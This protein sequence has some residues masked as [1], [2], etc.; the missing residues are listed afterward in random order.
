MTVPYFCS[1][2]SQKRQRHTMNMGNFEK[3]LFT[4]EQ[5]KIKFKFSLFDPLTSPKHFNLKTK[6]LGKNH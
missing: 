3:F 4:S 1:F 2:L 5:T 6:K